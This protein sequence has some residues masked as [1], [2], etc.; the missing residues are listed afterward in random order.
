MVKV[1]KLY[2]SIDYFRTKGKNAFVTD[3]AV[4]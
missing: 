2:F 4:L 3:E 1:R